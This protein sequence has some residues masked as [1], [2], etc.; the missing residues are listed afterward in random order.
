M[1][2]FSWEPEMEII[3]PAPML[4]YNAGKPRLDFLPTALIN[5]VPPQ[6]LLLDC[7][8]NVLEFGAKKY[9]P[10]NWRKSGSWLE[11]SGSAFRHYVKIF[12]GETHDSESGIH[13]A[14]HVLCNLG[15][16]LEFKVQKSGTDDRYNT[17]VKLPIR[18]QPGSGRLY[19]SYEQLLA[20]K[21]GQDT[22]LPQAAQLIAEWYDDLDDEERALVP[23]TSPHA[24][25]PAIQPE[26]IRAED[27]AAGAIHGH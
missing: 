20:W 25:I 18:K 23:G 9:D 26:S 24:F 6:F 17:A 22:G 8:A 27:I 19:E 12:R 14:G 5:V 13:H 1:M 16:L 4:R 3:S 15:F 10:N 11:V 7:T 2:A 21:D